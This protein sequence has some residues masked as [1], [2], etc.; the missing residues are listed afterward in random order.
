MFTGRVISVIFGL[1]LLYRGSHGTWPYF[2]AGSSLLQV[3]IVSVY[4]KDHNIAALALKAHGV[5]PRQR[6]RLSAVRTTSIS[7]TSLVNS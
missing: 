4:L 2:A 5:G 6:T 7:S 3:V 1:L